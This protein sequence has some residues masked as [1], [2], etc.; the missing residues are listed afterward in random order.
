M[1]VVMF[2]KKSTWKAKETFEKKVGPASH[3][4]TGCD[5]NRLNSPP[6]ISCEGTTAKCKVLSLVV[7]REEI[8]L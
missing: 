6:A 2:R 3:I 5:V 1:C 7:N 8:R 4:Q